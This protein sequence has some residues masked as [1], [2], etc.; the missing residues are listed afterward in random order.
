[1]VN[2]F[3]RFLNINTKQKKEMKNVDE[4]KTR[5]NEKEMETTKLCRVE[6]LVLKVCYVIESLG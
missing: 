2:I 4:S 1:M 3:A 5:W 6:E